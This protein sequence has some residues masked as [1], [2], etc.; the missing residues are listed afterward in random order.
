MTP[1][2]FISLIPAITALVGV[3]I[4]SG[5]SFLIARQQI[6]ATVIST[7]RVQWI[8]NFRDC[9]ADFQTKAKIA[10]VEAD[11]AFNKQTAYA[12]DVKNHDEAMK[13]M[14]FSANKIALL[15][16]PNEI[17]HSE[18]I[19]L[20]KQLEN[21]C[22]NGDPN[23]R[24]TEEKLQNSITSTGQKILKREWERVKLGL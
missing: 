9:V 13:G 20:I 11:L 24:T 23:E 22:A 6:K 5:V 7:N 18:L 2:K 15:L 1:D 19:L 17:D 8:N 21:H 10:L 12:A 4:G 14:C 3:V 16:N